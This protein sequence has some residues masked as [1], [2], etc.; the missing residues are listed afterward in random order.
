MKKTFLLLTVF[1]FYFLSVAQNIRKGQVDF[2]KKSKNQKTAAY[3]TLGCGVATLLPG[4]IL[5]GETRPGWENVDWGK[6][7]GGSGLVLVGVGCIT[8]SIILFIS[9]GHNQRRANKVSFHIN[10]PVLI[11]TGV[12]QKK[13]PYSIDVRIPIK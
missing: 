8:S 13:L 6:A 5:L 3:I 7:L 2:L 11:N 1:I 9:S 10:E 4:L 12:Q